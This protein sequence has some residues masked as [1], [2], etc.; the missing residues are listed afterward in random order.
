MARCMY[1]FYEERLASKSLALEWV[2]D[3]FAVHPDG[4]ASSRLFRL[5]LEYRLGGD[6][7]LLLSADGIEMFETMLPHF[8]EAVAR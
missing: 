2:A 7:K 5:L 6:E 3:R 8:R 4:A 1:S